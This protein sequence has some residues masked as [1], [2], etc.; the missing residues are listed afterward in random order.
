VL[1]IKGPAGRGRRA[2]GE[3][4]GAE[5]GQFIRKKFVRI[6]KFRGHAEMQQGKGHLSEER[7]GGE[8]D[9]DILK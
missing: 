9:P 3:S 5:S 2:R 1:K 6:E 7:G 8:F 4:V